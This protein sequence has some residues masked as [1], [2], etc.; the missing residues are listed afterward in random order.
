[1]QFDLQLLRYLRPEFTVYHVRSV[2]LVW[3]LEGATKQSHV[4]SIIAQS[5]S[6]PQSRNNQ[7]AYEAFGVLW[8]LTGL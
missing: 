2:N 1:M 5:L 8:R 4:Q 3:Q 6:S 7:G